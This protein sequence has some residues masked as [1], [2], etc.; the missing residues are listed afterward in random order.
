VTKTKTP[1]KQSSLSNFMTFIFKKDAT[2]SFT[3]EATNASEYNTQSSIST[4][5]QISCQ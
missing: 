3:S 4:M 5:G 2:P 1:T